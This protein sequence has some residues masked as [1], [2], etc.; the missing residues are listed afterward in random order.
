M[1]PR[2]TSM[3]AESHVFPVAPPP[4]RSRSSGMLRWAERCLL[5]VGLA[6]LGYCVVV[7]GGAALYQAQESSELDEILRGSPSTQQA[8]AMSRAPGNRRV[9]GRIEIP[10][11]GVS[12]IVRD[13]EDASTLRLAVGHIAGTAFPGHEGNVGLAGHRDTFFRRLADIKAG[14]LIRLV[15]TEHTFLYRVE[16]T[17]VVE[18]RDVWVLDPTPEQALTLV[19]CFPFSFIGTAPQR[20]IVRASRVMSDQPLAQARTRAAQTTAARLR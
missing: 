12:T 8:S 20:F 6:A 15:T 3:A 7:M 19:T 2:S 1:W 5:A 11:L 9:L 14:D 18:P 4:E 16:K 17:Q 13:G 10:S